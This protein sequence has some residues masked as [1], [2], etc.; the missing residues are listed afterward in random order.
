MKKVIC[1][2]LLIVSMMG[3]FAGCGNRQLFDTTYSFERAIIRL[4]NGEVVEGK[5][6]SWLD[7]EGESV[8]IVIDG[9]TYYTQTSNV[10]LI[11]E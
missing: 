2:C 11:S 8:Q 4:P 6:N 1:V 10:V 9:V 3:L 7:Y 5:V